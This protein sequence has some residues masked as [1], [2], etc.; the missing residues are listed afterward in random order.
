MFRKLGVTNKE[1]EAEKVLLTPTIRG[2]KVAV[3]PQAS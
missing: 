1:G 3:S 2:T